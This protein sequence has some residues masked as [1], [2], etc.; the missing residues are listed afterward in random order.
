MLP[1]VTIWIEDGSEGC[2]GERQRQRTHGRIVVES[3][4]I[5]LGRVDGLNVL[6][7]K[8]GVAEGE[9]GS[10]GE[11]AD[12]D[13]DSSSDESRRELEESRSAPRSRK[14]EKKRTGET[15]WLLMNDPVPVEM[16]EAL[17]STAASDETAAVLPLPVVCVERVT[18]AQVYSEAGTKSAVATRVTSAHWKRLDFLGPVW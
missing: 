6:L 12:D 10:E 8:L 3:G 9:E 1:R 11:E 14:E 5:V 15:F 2:G 7:A 18:L 13:G 17:V 4:R 16:V